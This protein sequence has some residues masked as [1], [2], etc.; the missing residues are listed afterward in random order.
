MEKG[1]VKWVGNS[2]DLAESV[3]S[4]FASV[5]EFDTSSYIHSKLYSANP[6]NMGK[7]SLLMEKNT[8]DVQLE[9]EEIIKAEQRK[10]GTVELI[11]YK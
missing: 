2:A 4:G 8:D 9:A 6:S 1:H 10:E 7:Q 5:N 11:V 3:Y